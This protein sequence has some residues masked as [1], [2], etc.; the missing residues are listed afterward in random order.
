MVYGFDSRIHDDL[1]RIH[2]DLVKINK[3]QRI[4]NRQATIN[5]ALQVLDAQSNADDAILSD[6]EIKQYY[7]VIVGELFA[8]ANLL[9]DFTK[10]MEE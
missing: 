4:A 5:N 8:D 9:D 3:E 7:H 10:E 6:D 1:V 2:E